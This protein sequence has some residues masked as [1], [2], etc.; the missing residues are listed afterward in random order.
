MVTPWRIAWFY[1]L[2]FQPLLSTDTS[3]SSFTYNNEWFLS[4]WYNHWDKNHSRSKSKKSNR[5][6]SKS[7]HS[8]NH[9]WTIELFLKNVSK[10]C[11]VSV[12]TYIN[13]RTKSPRPGRPVG[14]TNIWGG[15]EPETSSAAVDF[16]DTV[17]N[18]SLFMVVT[19]LPERLF[20]N[21]VSFNNDKNVFK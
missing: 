1:R 15:I 11:V 13:P 17:S 7:N 8:I 9:T 16:S 10:S 21:R 6:R 18:V 4:Q 20:N 2:T 14:H 5:N 19:E 3:P 12:L